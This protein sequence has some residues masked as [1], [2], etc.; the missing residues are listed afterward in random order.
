MKEMYRNQEITLGCDPEFFFSKDGK[1]IGSEVVIP[2][3]GI[4]SNGGL[5]VIDGVQA[6]LHPGQST[7]RELLANNIIL[8]LRQVEL[9]ATAK[10]VKADF[11]QVVEIEKE[12]LDKMD[13]ENKKFGCSASMN[14]HKEGENKITTVSADP[15]KY[16]K[17]SAGGHIHMGAHPTIGA[18]DPHGDSI[19]GFRKVIQ[20]ENPIFAV[21]KNPDKLVPVLDILV[22]NTC[23][24]LDTDPANKERRKN[25]GKAGEYRSPSYGI[26]YRTLSNFWLR[27][28]PLF[29]LAFGLARQ[30]AELVRQTTPENNY[31]GELMSLVK[32]DD[33][34]KAINENDKDLAARNFARIED[35]LIEIT[36]EDN[37]G[38]YPIM[39]ETIKGFHKLVDDGIDKYFTQDPLDA[40]LRPKE[41]HKAFREFIINVVNN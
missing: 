37:Y 36:Q 14:T 17:R 30:S 9:S 41:H 16:L 31:L 13:D 23:V 29:S 5:T 6:E 38:F 40:W 22:G 10:G 39:K 26:E 12:E 28:M 18:G 8:C 20:V 25:Y 1:I 24:M 33:I 3:K 15:L 21:L 11:S 35:F 34:T 32:M 19:N 2:K 7:C 27:G 4:A